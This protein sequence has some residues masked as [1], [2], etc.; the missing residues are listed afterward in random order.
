MATSRLGGLMAFT[1][2]DKTK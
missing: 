2:T 1:P